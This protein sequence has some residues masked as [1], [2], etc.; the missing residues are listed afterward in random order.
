ME[1]QCTMVAESLKRGL[2]QWTRSFFRSIVSSAV[3]SGAL[4][5]PV[6]FGTFGVLSYTLY[7]GKKF[8]ICHC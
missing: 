3:G 8:E 1:D 2:P 5:T 4:K 7:N 6:I